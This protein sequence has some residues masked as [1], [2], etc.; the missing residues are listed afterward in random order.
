MQVTSLGEA[1]AKIGDIDITEFFARSDGQFERG[2]FQVI[3]EDF[4]VVRLNEGVLRRVAKEIVRMANNELIERRGRSYQHGARA[5]AAPASAAGALPGGGD[6]AGVA[7]HDHGVERTDVNAELQSTGGND[8]SNFSVAE[9]AFDFAALVRQVAAAIAA[10][11]FRFSRQVRIRLLQIGEKNFG[12]QTRIGK[13]HGLHIV[14]QEFLGHARGFVD[15][16]AAD[17]QSAIHNGRIVK[18][19][20]FFR[21]GS[22]VGIEDFDFG[23]KKSCSEVS[24]VGDGGGTAD[25]LGIAAVKVGDAAEAAEN[26]AEVAAEDA[27]VGVQLIEDDVTE[28]FEEAGPARVVREDAGVQHVWVGQDDVTFFADGF[29]SVRGCVA[30]VGENAEAIFQTLVELV[31]FGELVLREGLG[32]EEVECAGVGIFKD[33]VQNREVIAERLAGSRWC[34]DNGVFSSAYGFGGGGLMGV[35]AADTFGGVGGDKI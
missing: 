26:I 1:R 16:A 10:N 32:G 8:A 27:A 21:G 18:D 13:D 35:E 15:I 7:G 5:S 34:D 14:F 31:K 19:E 6:G 25:E 23:F 17:A 20:G 9:A 29:A 3:D 28:V 30:V 2:A 4:Q 24:G 22:A 33:R 12:V 11:G